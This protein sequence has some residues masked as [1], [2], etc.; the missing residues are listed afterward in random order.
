MLADLAP[1]ATVGDLPDVLLK[2]R[3]S[4]Y[5]AGQMS[6]YN[7][8]RGA[9]LRFLGATLGTDHPLTVQC[10]RVER[11]K[12]QPKRK[13]GLTLD[14]LAA[15]L[16]YLPEKQRHV[17]REL[18]LTGMR[19]DEYYSGHF[20]VLSDR[21]EV[22]GTKT[23]A[24]VRVIPLVEPITGTTLKRTGM[25]HYLDKYP[26]PSLEPYT[27]RRTFANLMELA[28][29]PRTRRRMYLGHSGKDVTDLYERAEV[30]AFLVEDAERLRQA[31]GGLLVA[32]GLTLMK[33]AK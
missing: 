16:A 22:L 28:G 11:L 20:R 13:R 9:V 4:A 31:V 26:G 8:N 32:K 33:E 10:A 12:E 30:A 14:E 25:R 3:L 15:V 19:P 1:N 24:A 29:I 27:A 18:S 7:H 5:A 2:Y 6:G 17:F 23:K 21:I